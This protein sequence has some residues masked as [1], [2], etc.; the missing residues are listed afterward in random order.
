MQRCHSHPEKSDDFS[1]DPGIVGSPSGHTAAE[2]PRPPG[3]HFLLRSGLRPRRLRSSSRQGRSRLP[4]RSV[5][6]PSAEVSTGHPHLLKKSP[7]TPLKLST[8]VTGVTLVTVVWLYSHLSVTPV[9]AVTVGAK[10]NRQADHPFVDR[11]LYLTITSR[12][13]DAVFINAIL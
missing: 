10:S 2:N 11:G 3:T 7:C 9:T 13:V 1:G 12:K 4:A 6:L 8:P 5:L